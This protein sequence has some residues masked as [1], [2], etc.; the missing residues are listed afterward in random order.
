MKLPD[1]IPLG[2]EIE[3]ARQAGHS[4]RKLWDESSFA[5]DVGHPGCGLPRR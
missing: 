3:Q 2:Q 5:R 1:M 4:F